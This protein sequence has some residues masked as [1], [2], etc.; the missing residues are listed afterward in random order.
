MGNATLIYF[1]LVKRIFSL[2]WY[3]GANWL[4][5][6]HYIKSDNTS[7]VYRRQQTSVQRQ[8]LRNEELKK[9][10]KKNDQR[11]KNLL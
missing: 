9:K 6:V 8:I 1:S 10:K 5:H 11:R 2:T 3:L 4:T 7:I